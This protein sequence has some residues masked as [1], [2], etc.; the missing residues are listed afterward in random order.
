MISLSQEN[1]YF[2]DHFLVAISKI[3]VASW[4]RF[5]IT[6]KIIVETTKVAPHCNEIV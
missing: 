3:F 1:H 5:I 4:K 2:L 6:N